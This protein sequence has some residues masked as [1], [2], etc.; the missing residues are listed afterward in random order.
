MRISQSIAENS[1]NHF[2]TG[3]SVQSS[4]VGRIPRPLAVLALVCGTSFKQRIQRLSR[5]P[6]W[7]ILFA[8]S[9]LHTMPFLRHGPRTFISLVIWQTMNSCF[10]QAND[11]LFA[12]QLGGLLQ[13]SP[14]QAS[15][16]LLCKLG[17]FRVLMMAV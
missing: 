5:F 7:K 14:V 9:L 6:L 16:R 2:I 1:S 13:R 10:S 11:H 17:L 4:A 8:M 12:S 3:S 15:L